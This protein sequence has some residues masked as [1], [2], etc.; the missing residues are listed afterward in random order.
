MSFSEIINLAA[1]ERFTEGPVEAFDSVEF[2]PVRFL[3]CVGPDADLHVWVQMTKNCQR[4][5]TSDKGWMDI[6]SWYSPVVWVDKATPTI[7]K[8]KR[9]YECAL[10]K[11]FGD[12]EKFSTFRPTREHLGEWALEFHAWL[13]KNR[14]K[15]AIISACSNLKK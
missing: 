3:E 7:S 6:R 2:S 1:E 4:T 11:A 10:S 8:Y 13:Q 5:W 15:S 12:S 14:A 9:E